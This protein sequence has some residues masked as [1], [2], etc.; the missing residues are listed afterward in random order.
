MNLRNFGPC[1]K[2]VVRCALVTPFGE[3][4]VGENVCGNPQSVCPREEGEG[5]EKCKTICQQVGHAEEVAIML[6]GNKA[7]GAKAYLD[8]HTYYCRNCQEALFDAGVISLSLEQRVD[9]VEV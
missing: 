4:F 9:E 1:A 2:R 7:D 3:E 6:A 5:Y 8:G